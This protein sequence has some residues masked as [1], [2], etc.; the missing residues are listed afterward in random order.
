MLDEAAPAT[1]VLGRLFLGICLIL[2]AFN[3]RPLFPSLSVLLPEVTQALGMSGAVAG[4][5][6]TLPVL[7]LGLFAPFAPALADRH[8]AERV[9]LLVLLLIG[10]GTLLR[11]W[12]ATALLF[13]GSAMAGAGIA[14]GNVLL[15][16]V[17]KRDFPDKVALMTG[18][19]T[20]ALCGGAA[21]AAAFTVPLAQLGGSWRFGLAAWAVPAFAIALLW[22]P[23]SLRS[24]TR[25]RARRQPGL[26]LWHDGLAWQV[27]CF[28][29]LQSA[30]AYCVMGWMAPIL[31]WRGLDGATAGFYVSASVMVQVATCLLVP[32]LAARFR[33][34]SLFN[35]GL[36]LLAGATLLALLVA[37]ARLLFPLALLQGIGQGG[38]FAIAMTVIILRSPDSRTA[39]R[40]SGMSQAIG[41]LLAALGPML[42]GMLHSATG[43]YAATGWLFAGIGLAAMASGWGAGRPLFVKPRSVGARE[44]GAA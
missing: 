19:F 7:C 11:T 15:P 40:L 41:Y 9:L 2:I 34:Q 35:A 8:G 36:A 13:I 38:L 22:L 6:T 12:D 4:Y 24:G 1:P 23:R 3:L 27:S 17:V 44:E 20:M 29:G 30:L 42:V 32:P 14:M 10:A 5:L 39:A 26:R 21:A 31:R 18:L 25:G 28:M 37:P 43:S 16:S 33:S